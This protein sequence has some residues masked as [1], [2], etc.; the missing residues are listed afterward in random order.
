MTLPAYYKIPPIKF[1]WSNHQSVYTKNDIFSTKK[2]RQQRTRFRISV[3]LGLR[4]T[5]T[6]YFV[7]HLFVLEVTGLY[8]LPEWRRE[9]YAQLRQNIDNS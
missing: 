1:I 4:L 2:C 5:G 6:T 9:H 8:E 3:V 7:L